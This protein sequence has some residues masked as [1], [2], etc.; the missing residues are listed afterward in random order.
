MTNGMKTSEFFVCVAVLVLGA[1]TSSGVISDG[2]TVAKIVGGAMEVLAA[3]GYT[4]SRATVKL[5]PKSEKPS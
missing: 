4:W 2:G 1:L 3:L 5:G